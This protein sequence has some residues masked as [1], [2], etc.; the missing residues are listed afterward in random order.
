[1][2]RTSTNNGAN[3]SQSTFAEDRDLLSREEILSKGRDASELLNSTL[4]N[5]AYEKLVNGYMAEII[6]TH[7]KDSEQREYL[8]HKVHALGDVAMEINAYLS[9]A[10]GLESQDQAQ[11]GDSQREVDSDRGFGSDPEFLQ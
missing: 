1:M 8:Y 10:I 6:N 9:E 4:F 3:N 5:E 7:P 11:Q 2:N